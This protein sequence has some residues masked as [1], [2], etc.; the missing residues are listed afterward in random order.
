[1]QEC[2][3]RKAKGFTSIYDKSDATLLADIIESFNKTCFEEQ[4]SETFFFVSLLGYIW[5][6]RLNYTNWES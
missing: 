5:D 6:A 2:N 3:L 4:K 1:M